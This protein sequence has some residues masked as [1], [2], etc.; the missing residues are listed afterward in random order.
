MVEI[1]SATL[2]DGREILYFD[3]QPHP[4][5]VLVDARDIPTVSPLPKCAGIL[6]GDWVALPPTA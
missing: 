4:D 1:T 6:T 5:R 2:A 3:D